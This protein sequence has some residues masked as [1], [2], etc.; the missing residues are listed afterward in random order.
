MIENHE[1]CMSEENF[2]G[3]EAGYIYEQELTFDN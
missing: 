2:N 1:N 3:I